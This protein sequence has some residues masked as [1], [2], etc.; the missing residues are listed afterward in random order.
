MITRSLGETDSWEQRLSRLLPEFGHRN[1]IVV[2]DSAY[3]AQA[4]AGIETIYTGEDHLQLLGKVLDAI[5]AQHHIRGKA[6]VDAEL[7]HVAESDAPGVGEIRGSLDRLLGRGARSLEHEQIIEKLDE[8][9]RLFNILILK[10]T[11]A[12]PYTSVFIELDCGYWNADAEKRLRD[13]VQDAT[14]AAPGD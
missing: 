13:S 5:A 6:Y 2:A 1:W 12:I 14:T 4:N 9:A 3:P 8:S 7:K 11:L 10:S